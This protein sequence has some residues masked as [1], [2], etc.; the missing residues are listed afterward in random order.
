LALANQDDSNFCLSKNFFDSTK[1]K[2]RGVKTPLL[3]YLFK[4][5]ATFFFI[6]LSEKSAT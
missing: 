1:I 3:I 6:L 5:Y 2:K 4:V